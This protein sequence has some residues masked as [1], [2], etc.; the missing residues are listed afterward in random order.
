MRI[1]YLNDMRIMT[2]KTWNI[3]GLHICNVLFKH[4]R[5]I[6]SQSKLS[7]CNG[8]VGSQ[9]MTLKSSTAKGLNHKYGTKNMQVLFVKL[10]H[11]YKSRTF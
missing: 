11:S 5:S 2:Y 4:K 10:L 1:K 6:Y 8:E 7:P 3:P 9:S